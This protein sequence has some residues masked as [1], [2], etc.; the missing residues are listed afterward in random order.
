MSDENEKPA[1][2]NQVFQTT[3]SSGV[4]RPTCSSC[5]FFDAGKIPISEGFPG[6]CR[7]KS[8]VFG[9]EDGYGRWWSVT[10]KDWCGDHPLTQAMVSSLQTKAVMAPAMEGIQKLLDR[11]PGA[12][13]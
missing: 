12:G 4:A 13:T 3:D 1:A 9:Q 11:L 2:E 7:R 5:P 10:A 6:K 8:P